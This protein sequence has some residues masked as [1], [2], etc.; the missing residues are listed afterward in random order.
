M[1]LRLHPLQGWLCG[2]TMQAV[3][4]EKAIGCGLPEVNALDVS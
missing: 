3:V 1:Y 4:K 2:A